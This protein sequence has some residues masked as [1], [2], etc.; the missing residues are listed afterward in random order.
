[1]STLKTIATTTGALAAAATIA[2]ATIGTA[3]WQAAPGH[4]TVCSEYGCR[5]CDDIAAIAA[6]AD[7]ASIDGGD[8]IAELLA[9][10]DGELAAMDAYL[11]GGD[12]GTVPFADGIGWDW[13]D[14]DYDT[15]P[16]F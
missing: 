16:T 10:S 6:R 8:D 9:M 11:D 15:A 7:E 1:M 12:D 13:P 4:L 2:D 5:D 3:F 14:T